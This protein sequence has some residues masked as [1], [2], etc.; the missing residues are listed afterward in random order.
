MDL[1]GDPA[2]KTGPGTLLELILHREQVFCFQILVVLCIVSEV[3]GF[4]TVHQP[5]IQTLFDAI[6]AEEVSF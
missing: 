3:N 6:I 5:P 1:T 2:F 4:Y